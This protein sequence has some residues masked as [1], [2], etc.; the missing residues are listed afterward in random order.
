M[1]LLRGLCGC[2][3]PL[4]A[5]GR[6]AGGRGRRPR[7]AHPGG[8]T[9]RPWLA[10]LRAGRGYSVA[11]RRPRAAGR[12]ARG[13]VGRPDRGPVHARAAGPPTPGGTGV[14]GGVDG[15]PRP[16]AAS[17]RPDRPVRAGSPGLALRHGDRS[18][19]A[20]HGS[21]RNAAGLSV[22]HAVAAPPPADPGPHARGVRGQR[23]T[24]VPRVRGDGAVPHPDPGLRRDDG[25]QREPAP[26]RSGGGAHAGLL[27]PGPVRRLPDP[28][29]AR[30]SFAAC[31]CWPP[32]WRCWP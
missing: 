12:G 9:G 11:I 29:H 8:G 22:P 3:D 14:H 5:G 19:R 6:A 15:W 17:G 21:C 28:Q 13:S 18:A 32:A 2:A 30:C 23:G 25:P 1:R 4:A 20:G 31:H 16:R 27:D 7:S 10:G 24:G 26:G